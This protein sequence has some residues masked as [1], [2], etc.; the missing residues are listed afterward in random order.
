MT[1]HP[2]VC[3]SCD[4]LAGQV[5]SGRPR[6]Q[7]GRRPEAGTHPLPIGRPESEKQQ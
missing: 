7:G 6:P 3:G 4:A 1:A 2:V 5:R